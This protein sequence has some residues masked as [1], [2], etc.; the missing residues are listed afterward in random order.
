MLAV[1]RSL[2]AGPLRRR[3]RDHSMTPTVSPLFAA[4]LVAAMHAAD[5]YLTLAGKLARDR[6]GGEEFL[7]VGGSYE[8]NPVFEKAVDRVAWVSPRFLLS[9]IL[10]P[11][12]FALIA[13]L[14]TSGPTVQWT[15]PFLLGAFVFHR[16]PVIA[17]H[18]QN[19]W[20][21]RMRRL[22]QIR[23]SMQLDRSTVLT[24]SAWY[25]A[26]Y[27]AV[28]GVAEGLHPNDWFLG[29][30]FGLCGLSVYLLGLSVR[31]RKSARLASATSSHP[32]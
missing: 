9:L 25:Y 4:L 23:G 20:T 13:W 31:A 17:K 14:S 7:S 27:A 29:G 21:F 16:V 30:L 28:L 32:A 8:L 24:Q 6:A 2:G 19:L 1:L 15:L 5:Y 22:G 10:L 18:L 12:A 3:P 11:F 26:G